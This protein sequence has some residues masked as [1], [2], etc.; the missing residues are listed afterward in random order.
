MDRLNISLVII[1][2]NQASSFIRLSMIDRS[3]MKWGR[4]RATRFRCLAETPSHDITVSERI[5]SSLSAQ[6]RRA[7][8]LEVEGPHS[9]AEDWPIAE[10]Q[11]LQTS[12]YSTGTKDIV[13][14]HLHRH[15]AS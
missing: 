5:M 4:A 6:D 10:R 1:N 2:D 7:D 8:S 9:I 14:T 3:E 11:V 15:G 13:Q 12:S